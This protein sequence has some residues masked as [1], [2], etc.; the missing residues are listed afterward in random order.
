MLAKLPMRHS[1]ATYAAGRCRRAIT[2]QPAHR[3]T[4]SRMPSRKA[5][6]NA[7]LIAV[8]GLVLAG[9]VATA[10]GD[11]PAG[12]PPSPASTTV[13]VDAG[14]AAPSSSGGPTSDSDAAAREAEAAA[15]A[16]ADAEA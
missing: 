6:T 13:W 7:V 3:P 15:A 10:Q 2:R 14:G 16:Q 11:G 4:R 9:T 1:V 5:T 8:A 12:A